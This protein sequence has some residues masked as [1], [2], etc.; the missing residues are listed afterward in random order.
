MVYNFLSEKKIRIALSYLL[1]KQLTF[2][3]RQTDLKTLY[4]VKTIKKSFD[5]LQLQC[6]IEMTHF[7]F[8]KLMVLTFVCKSF[9]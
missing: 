6:L 4:D 1:H 3:K 5:R 7:K 9:L 2:V 8:K